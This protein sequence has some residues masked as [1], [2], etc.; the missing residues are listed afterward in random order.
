MIETTSHHWNLP[1]KRLQLAESSVHVWRADLTTASEDVGELLSADE[2]VRAQRFVFARDRER[3]VR[4]RGILRALLGNY[5][6]LDASALR[7]TIG[8][9]GKPA[10]LAESAR[11]KEC[12]DPSTQ[13]DDSSARLCFNLSH[14]ED[15]TLYAFSRI[16]VGVDVE[17][18][19]PGID[20][21]ALAERAFG[22]AEAVRLRR[23]P[24]PR[25][26][27]EFLRTWVR[28]EASLKCRGTRLGARADQRELWLADLDV[29]PGAAA[30]IALDETPGQLCLWEWSAP[31]G[32]SSATATTR[33]ANHRSAG[34]ER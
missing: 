19:R 4:S 16:Q 34:T 6:D 7:F 29:G 33:K 25:R 27:R 13:V 5:L 3:W 18:V 17:V 30:A 11:S 26:S 21:I 10:L 23:L 22:H 14:S 32:H 28:H 15:L 20:V 2:R 9:H 24:A 12:D 8:S 31:K 1:P